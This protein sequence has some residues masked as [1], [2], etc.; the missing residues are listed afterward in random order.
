MA[1]INHPRGLQPYGNLLQVTEYTLSTAYAQDLFIW[2]PVVVNGTSRDVVIA[3]AGTGNAISGVIVGIYDLNKVPLQYWDSGHT[4]IGYVLVADDPRQVFIA[5]GDG[6]VSFL[7]ADDAN[8][9]INLVSG[10]GSTVNYL[11]GW[12]LDDSDT[13]GSTAGDQIRLI[14]PDQRDDN[15]VGIANADWLCRINNHTA[16]AGI[17]GVGV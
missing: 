9:N 7:D 5:Q 12:E 4:G 6:A 10:S 15:T 11:S 8:G 13:G 14:R 17:V 3:T 2:D 1:N 16:N